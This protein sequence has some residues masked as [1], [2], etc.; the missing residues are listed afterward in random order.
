MANT[1]NVYVSG[2]VYSRFRPC[3][4][5]VVRLQ[6]TCSGV[7]ER[8]VFLWVW[9]SAELQSVSPAEVAPC[10]LSLSGYLLIKGTDQLKSTG[11][12]R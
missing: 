8:W 1:L 11:D 3:S 5:R 9:L 6:V 12:I 7:V 10:T 4:Q 2:L